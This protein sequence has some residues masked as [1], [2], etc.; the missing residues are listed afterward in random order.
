[1]PRRARI[2]VPGLPLHLVQRGNN[3]AACFHCDDD[4]RFYLHHLARLSG[5]AACEVHAYCLMTNHVHLLPTPR[6][7]DSAAR[8]MRRLDLLHSQ[9]LNR[10]YRRTGSVWEGRFRSC[11]VESESYLLQCYRY[12][13][14]NPVRAGM[15]S[16]PD[17]YCWSSHGF[18]TAAEPSSWLVPHAEYLRLASST[19]ERGRQ[20]RAL[21]DVEVDAQG[22][23][24]AT[25]G[26]RA[27]GT[28]PFLD[29]LGA[30]LGRPVVPGRPGRPARRGESDTEDLVAAAENV[31]RP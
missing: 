15:V 3:K 6:G 20:Y 13:E 17:E 22:I 28:K 8:L 4:R 30:S 29:A 23:R 1:M 12:I 9:Y 2:T 24:D 31:V 7:A 19:Q 21:F 16:R 27:L 11:V 5:Q 25:N 18:N 14:A 26:N 10:K